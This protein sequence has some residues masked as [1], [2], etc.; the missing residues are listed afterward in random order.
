MCD[1]DAILIV[2]NR[3]DG[4]A[5]GAPLHGIP[6]QVELASCADALRDAVDKRPDP[7]RDP[8]EPQRGRN[9]P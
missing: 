7:D 3:L 2:A 8:W 6:L 5:T 9:A 4:L 1:V